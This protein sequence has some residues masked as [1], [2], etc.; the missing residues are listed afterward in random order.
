MPQFSM[1]DESELSIGVPVMA[2]SKTLVSRS[3]FLDED[4]LSIGVLVWL[5]GMNL[6]CA[7]VSQSGLLDE[8]RLSIRVPG[9]Q[10]NWN[11]EPPG[12]RGRIAGCSAAYCRILVSRSGLL[13]ESRLAD[14]LMSRWHFFVSNKLRVSIAAC[15]MKAG[16]VLV[17]W[18]GLLDESML[19]WYPSLACW[20]STG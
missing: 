2:T 17:P 20:M 8:S 15:W 7:V 16:W 14:V 4:R 12:Q 9:T 13:D 5:T 11:T 6:S 18:P 10:R 3:G 19:H 1:L